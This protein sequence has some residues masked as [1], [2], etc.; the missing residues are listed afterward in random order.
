MACWRVRA[1]GLGE[2]LAF[3]WFIAVSVAFPVVAS[4]PGYLWP[5]S[6][7]PV[8][9]LRP[10][11]PS[12]RFSVRNTLADTIQVGDPTQKDSTGSTIGLAL[13]GT[14]TAIVFVALCYTI[15]FHQAKLKLARQ[16]LARG[17]LPF[18]QEAQMTG[19]VEEIRVPSPVLFESDA[20]ATSGIY[21]PT[22][23]IPKSTF[24]DSTEAGSSA[25]YTREE[26]QKSPTRPAEAKMRS[27]TPE[28]K[29]LGRCANVRSIPQRGEE[30]S[31]E[32]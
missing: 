15:Y 11:L 9:M 17:L 27:I 19:V 18:S 6:V 4:V 24:S 23:H 16:A 7:F 29:V 32:D 13:C 31:P 30:S 2:T 1:H 20:D 12:Q 22:V 28:D 14:F 25:S 21:S 8:S 10:T 3:L 26:E 5:V